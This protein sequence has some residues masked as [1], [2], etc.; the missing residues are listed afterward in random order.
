MKIGINVIVM[1]Q[2]E[3]NTYFE[4]NHTDNLDVHNLINNDIIKFGLFMKEK[5]KKVENLEEKYLFTFYIN[6]KY[7]C[8]E[9]EKTMTGESQQIIPKILKIDLKN[10]IKNFKYCVILGK[11]EK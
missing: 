6:N 7:L 2:E 10:K 3:K 8:I 9:I 4:L 11:E 1:N 5:Y